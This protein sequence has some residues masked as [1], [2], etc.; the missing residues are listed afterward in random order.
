MTRKQSFFK[1][2]RKIRVRFFWSEKTYKVH[3]LQIVDSEMIVYKFYLHTKKNWQY[4]V[5]HWARLRAYYDN[6][7]KE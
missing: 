4:E 7:K 5:Q 6:V 1:P 3:I 2:G